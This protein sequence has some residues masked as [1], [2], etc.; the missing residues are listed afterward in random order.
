MAA[1]NMH[2]RSAPYVPQSVPS[3]KRSMFDIVPSTSL[4]IHYLREGEWQ[5]EI[6]F[7]QNT[8]TSL[9]KPL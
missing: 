2:L 1:A 5:Q 6:A 3:S 4:P 7:L 9:P 8:A